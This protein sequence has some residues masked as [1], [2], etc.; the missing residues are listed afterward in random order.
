M[1]ELKVGIQTACLRMP[2][3]KALHTAARLGARAVEI[4]A[5]SELRPSELTQTGVRHIRKMLDDVNLRVC[6]VTFRTRR[7]YNVADDLDRRLEAT[8]GALKMAYD[9][10]ANVV[11][12]QVGRVPAESDGAEWELL[13][14][15]LTELGL[16]SQKT[17]AW[18]AA[19]TGAEDAADLKR[20]IDALPAGSIAIDLDP[21]NLIINGFS[22]REAAE[23]LGEHVMHVHARDGVRD[24]AQGRGIE[25]QLGRGSAEFPELLGVLEEHEYRGFFTVERQHARNAVQEVGDAV[26]FLRQI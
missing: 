20:L 2:F 5:R 17:G 25:V 23:T 15:S 11:V 21:G 16:F 22:A 13:V 3:R 1:L 10:G 26:K 6:A 12:N 9:L 7:G 24:L 19:K 14:E 8:K 4:D 18:L